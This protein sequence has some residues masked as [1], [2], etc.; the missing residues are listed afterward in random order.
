VATI[1]PAANINPLRVGVTG[2]SRNGKGSMVAGAFEDRLAL[3]I[4]QE[5]GQGSAECS[6][7]ADEI[8]KQGATV[9]TAH[10]IVNGDSWYSTAFL[11]MGG[12]D[13]YGTV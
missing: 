4:P 11:E 6:R 1:T 13:S 9:E 3:A 5:G 2:C 12:C 10:Q 7:I 8:K